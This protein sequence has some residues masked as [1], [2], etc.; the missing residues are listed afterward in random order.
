MVVFL[1]KEEIAHS[2]RV[3]EKHLV[4]ELFT[5]VRARLRKLTKVD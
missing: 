5:A 2:D 4:K 3:I 1:E